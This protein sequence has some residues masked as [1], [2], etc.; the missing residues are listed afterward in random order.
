MTRR[1]LPAFILSYLAENGRPA[2]ASEIT[3]AV[4]TPRPT[5]NRALAALV[6]EG[7][8]RKLGRG[9]GTRYERVDGVPSKVVEPASPKRPAWPKDQQFLLGLVPLSSRS[10]AALV[11]NGCSRRK[12][13]MKLDSSGSVRSRS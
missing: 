12:T 3:S 4:Q 8:L 5:V 11:T 7:Q 13:K 1:D 10:A 6:A 2:S 9:A